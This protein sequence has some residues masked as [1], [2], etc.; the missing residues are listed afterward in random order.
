MSD[1]ESRCTATVKRMYRNMI[2]VL[3]TIDLN[4][5]KLPDC[6][7]WIKH[8]WGY[9][10]T[11]LERSQM[12]PYIKTGYSIGIQDLQHLSNWLQRQKHLHKVY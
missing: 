9:N 2:F 1:S 3:L 8:E 10:L 5:P 6:F 7:A 12:L 4:K 11:T